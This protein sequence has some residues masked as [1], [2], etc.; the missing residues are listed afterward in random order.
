MDE[1]SSLT[2]DSRG[3]ARVIAV[4]CSAILIGTMID[5]AGPI[6]QSSFEAEVADTSVYAH[7]G[8]GED[9][10]PT[11]ALALGRVVVVSGP[12]INGWA[13][14]EPPRESFSWIPA[15]AARENPDG[16]ASIVT[17]ATKVRLGS[18]LSDAHYVHQVELAR[19]DQVLVV[20]EQ[21]LT[22][23]D[24]PRRWFKIKPPTGER[25]YIPAKSLRV[26]ETGKPIGAVQQPNV[27][28]AVD[29]QG[30]SATQPHSLPSEPQAG[31]VYPIAA[32]VGTRVIPP[33]AVISRVDQPAV[34]D[35]PKAR[36]VSR[37]T[38]GGFADD[39][40]LPVAQRAASLSAHLD[41]IR[42]QL[43]T[44]WDLASA[45]STL[46]KLSK[47]ASTDADRAALAELSKK[48]DGMQAASDRYA[49][50]AER[51]E[52]FLKQDQELAKR[53]RQMTQSATSTFAGF[54]AEGVLRVSRAGIDGTTEYVLEDVA[55]RATARV[56]FPPG[57]TGNSYIGRR[58][59]L[60]GSISKA[61]SDSLPTINVDQ[62]TPL[63]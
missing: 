26:L 59:G 47:S 18:Q 17:D 10:Y 44:E 23:K 58:V 16:T 3:I 33:A 53:V 6:G 12:I 61:G 41:Q 36:P 27:S 38:G 5:P 50:F 13:P 57:L 55:G 52:A 45:K 37:G 35:V 24:G 40:S 51:R 62:V 46:N 11:T 25:R 4:W 30:V 48:L 20:D 28:F 7:A 49:S 63:P 2:G 29:R 34:A 54:D 56:V 60:Y 15:D 14:I 42:A 19:G 9:Y 39:P 1:Y 21:T 31:A 32:R 22:D 8:P 43:P